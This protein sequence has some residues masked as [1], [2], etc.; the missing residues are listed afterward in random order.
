MS[1]EVSC[2][3]GLVFTARKLQLSELLEL[4]EAAEVNAADGGLSRV[5]SAVWEDLVSEGP[6]AFTMGA[7]PGNWDP[8]LEGDM[9]A[10][11]RKI[12]IE[13]IGPFV[14]FAFRCE[15]C[16]KQQDDA[17][18]V[19]LS[20]LP[21][22]P[23]P[24]ESIDKHKAGERFQLTLSNGCV[25]Q[26]GLNTIGGHRH[27]QNIK[28]QYKARLKKADDPRHV[29]A[30]RSQPYDFILQC[31]HSVSELGD[32]IRDAK[33]F[34]DWC[35]KLPLE[36]FM[37]MSETLEDQIGGVETKIPAVCAHCDWRQENA[38]L[39]L[40]GAFW[41]RPRRKKPESKTSELESPSAS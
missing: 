26:Y 30:L 41:K 14:D 8:L 37:L 13:S 38:V 10:A 40:G 29:K 19:D 31:V 6:Y 28:A 36:D 32:F 25:V 35:A 7:K 4:A 12:R 21:T 39:P 3:S 20:A 27:V 9:I 15:S 2:P 33:R 1:Y 23:Y 22:K 34:I 18:E 11:L 17:L 5:L 16:G 24:Q